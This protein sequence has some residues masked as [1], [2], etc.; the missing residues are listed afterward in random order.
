MSRPLKPTFRRRSVLLL[1]VFV[2][3]GAIPGG[4]FAYFNSTGSGS[5]TA[6]VGTLN[7]PT[8]V[9]ATAA[10][11]SGM[12]AVSWTA[13][14]TG[15]N[16]VAPQGYYVL[17]YSGSAP[18]AACDTSPAS[19]TTNTSCNDLSVGDGTYTYTVVAKYHSWTVESAHSTPAITVIN[20]IIAPT[21]TA[22]L[23]P[24]PNA[25]GWNKA[26]VLVTLDAA[27]NVGGSSVKSITYSASG[28]QTIS[29]TTVFG[30]TTSFTINT[31]GTTTITFYATDNSGNSE[32]PANTQVVKIDATKPTI[33]ASAK[34]ADGSTYSAG[35]WTNQTVT[36]HYTCA[37]S[38]G[39]S[40]ASC[41][42]GQVFSA[43]RTTASTSGTAS[44]NAANSNTASFGPIQID[45]V[46]P[47]PAS[48]SIPARINSTYSLTN[49][50]RD[51]NSGV[52]SVHYY[53]CSGSCRPSPGN[54]GTTEIGTGSTTGPNYSVAWSSQPTDGRYS[55]IAQVID[56]AGNKTNSNAVTTTVDN[57]APAVT[58]TKVNGSTATFPLSTNTTVTTI[59]GACTAGAGD[60]STITWSVTGDA[61]E[62]GTAICTTLAWSA[63][64]TTALSANGSYSVSA[65]QS[66]TAA[67]TPNTGS[68]GNK[69]IQIDKTQPTGID[70]QAIPSGTA[71]G[72]PSAG[73]KVVYA[74]SKQMDPNTILA[75]WTGAST[76]VSAS[77]TD[78]G[79]T[80]TL[81]IT[82]VNLGTV[83]LG[84][85]YVRNNG[86]AYAF[87]SSVMVMTTD[88]SGRSVVTITLGGTPKKTPQHDNNARTM[89]WTPSSSAKDLFGNA[90]LTSPAIRESGTLD[91][92]F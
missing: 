37:D 17:R 59:G 69:P 4:A 60:S 45:K 2:A 74:F 62:S 53:Y 78:N 66:D 80:D 18:S 3:L 65:T 8:T 50:A 57:T 89:T 71:D 79:S 75:G 87:D 82:G 58:L 36:V 9:V 46:N 30:E 51:A 83:N 15:G 90:M 84:G 92:D 73:D 63:T 5:S 31:E 44:D 27:D 56:K 29:Q 43:T 7:A 48:L 41:T 40:L 35:T 81:T 32:S 61:T 47:I 42:A 55:V 24:L 34:N 16:A 33:S 86:N 10:P 22:T 28:A 72:T 70:V 64:L 39:S 67:T 76:T 14:A 77:F 54:A 11:G 23:S 49:A 1:A 85:N 91:K 21:S 52:A 12:V 26:D 38:G 88:G 19:L 6:S 68:S 20:D 13:S 25:E